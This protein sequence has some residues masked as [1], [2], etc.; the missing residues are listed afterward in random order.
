ML[1]A[2]PGRL[3]R[4]ASAFAQEAVL[5]IMMTTSIVAGEMLSFGITF[6]KPVDRLFVDPRPGETTAAR[7]A[8]LVLRATTHS[9]V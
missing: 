7:S 5:T 3:I 4:V 9:P 2:I 8:F 6:K 1:K